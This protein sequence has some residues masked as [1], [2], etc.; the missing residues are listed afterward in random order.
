MKMTKA[1]TARVAVATV[2]GVLLAGVAGAAFADE[3]DND[4]VDVNVNIAAIEPVGALTMSVAQSSTSLAEVDSGDPEV[5]Q[6]DGVLPTVTVT[7]DRAEVPADTFW[8]VN[9]QSSA[10]T[11]T[12]LPEIGAEHLGWT[13]AL[14]SDDSDGDVAAGPQ[15]DTVLDEGPNAVGLVG[16]ELLAIAPN[17]GELPTGSWTANANLFLKTPVDVA[18]GAYKATITLTLWE[19][20]IG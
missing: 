11:G 1:M 16:E 12:G 17:F 15:V 20:P 10:F 4:Q 3:A 8:Y 9:G 18:P 6:F 2:G 5:R 14:T 19:D 7:D 13:P